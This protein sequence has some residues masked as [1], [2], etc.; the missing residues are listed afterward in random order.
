MLQKPRCN[1]S[2]SEYG[3]ASL[4]PRYASALQHALSAP[5]KSSCGHMLLKLVF[6]VLLL[7]QPLPVLNG[8]TMKRLLQ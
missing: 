2:V 8:Y 5:E 3:H 7:L 1:V 6:A 4:G